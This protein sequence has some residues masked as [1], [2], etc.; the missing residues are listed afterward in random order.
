MTTPIEPFNTDEDRTRVLTEVLR[1]GGATDGATLVGY[2]D[3]ATLAVL[4]VKSLATPDAILDDESCFSGDYVRKLSDVLCA[5]AQ[6]CAPARVRSGGEWSPIAGDLITVV[7]RQ[8]D[9]AI[10]PT[11]I[12]FHL[13]WRYSSHLTSAFESE[14]YAVT[15]QGWASLYGQSSGSVPTLPIGSG[16]AA[17]NAMI[18]QAEGVL[19]ELASGL[20]GPRQGECVLCYVYRMIGEFGCDCRLRFATHYRDVRA[21]R[22]TGLER[23]L[24]QTGGYCDCEIFLNGYEP[25]PQ[26]WVPEVGDDLA[27]NQPERTWP[28]LMPACAGVRGGSTQPC[29][30]WCRQYRTW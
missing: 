11:E 27:E 16:P 10:A 29:S 9:A 5:V 3:P 30:L 22:A 17:S 26:Y 28:D 20:L 4:T 12:R 15:P 7:C 13:G 19:E 25:R 2:V 6:S 1:Q 18:E 21:P 14:V 8:G 23:R 24:G